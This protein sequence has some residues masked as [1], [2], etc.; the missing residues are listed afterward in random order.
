MSEGANLNRAGDPNRPADSAESA[1]SAG[2]SAS[3][4]SAESAVAADRS[5]G[6][7][8]RVVALPGDGI[9]R[10]V[11]AEGLRVLRTLQT[12]SLP[13]LTVE[14]IPCGAQYFVEDGII[15]QAECRVISLT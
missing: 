9:G 3:G 13:G 1:G 8:F 6:P 12:S 7:R 14:V 4:V 2:S 15:R 5:G 10:E 11:M